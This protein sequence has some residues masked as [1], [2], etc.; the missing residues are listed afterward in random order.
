MAN[1]GTQLFGLDTWGAP[2]SFFTPG[3]GGPP[4]IISGGSLVCEVE[5][6]TIIT[7]LGAGFFPEFVPMVFSGPFGGPYSLVAEGYLFD[8][9]FDLTPTQAIVGMPALPAGVY[10]LAVRTPSGQ[11]NVLDSAL[12]YKPFADEEV[13]QKGRSSWSAKWHVGIRLGA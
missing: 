11:S 1:W 3:G 6:G 10:G 2:T 13:A 7:I 4:T 9:D 12:V 5:G 8:P